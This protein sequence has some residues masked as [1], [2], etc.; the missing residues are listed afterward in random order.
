MDMTPPPEPAADLTVL[1]A[2]NA[3]LREQVRQLLDTIVELRSTVEKQQAH[4]D[5]LVRLSFGRSSERLDGPTLFDDCPA[6]EP[7]T[8]PTPPAPQ[9]TS[10]RVPKRP[11]HG[12]QA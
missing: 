10:A 7:V 6:P 12:R 9:P 3:H 11:G 5:R 4:I 1:A 8:P 2:E